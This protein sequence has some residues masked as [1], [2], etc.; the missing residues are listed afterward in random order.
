MQK[1]NEVPK[2]EC[3]YVYLTSSLSL[4]PFRSL[5]Y[6]QLIL[7]IVCI[8]I[9]LSSSFLS[10]SLL[11]F[12]KHANYH[13]SDYLFYYSPIFLTDLPHIRL[14]HL[15][16]LYE[17]LREKNFDL[18]MW[19]YENDN[20]FKYALDTADNMKSILLILVKGDLFVIFFKIYEFLIFNLY[21][22]YIFVPSSNRC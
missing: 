5:L 9:L 17:N 4:P 6:K 11:Y 19:F 22:F 3:L 10:L 14:F 8:L 12:S 2:F 15:N 20:D 7:Y 21:R 13:L 1:V 16:K 18:K